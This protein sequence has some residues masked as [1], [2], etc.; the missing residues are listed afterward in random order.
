MIN[1]SEITYTL[2][3]KDILANGDLRKTRNGKVRSVFNKRL[4]IKASE[5]PLLSQ[6][7]IN[8]KQVAGELATFISGDVNKVTLNE[9]GCTYWDPIFKKFPKTKLLY[10]K[11]WRNFNGYDQLRQVIYTLE[12][13][14]TSRRILISNA[15][16]D[17][18]LSD[19]LP[20]CHI[21]YQWYVTK[22]GQLEMI[23][24]QRSVDV[25]IG[26]PHDMV[27]ASLFNRLLAMT[28]GLKCGNIYMN[29]GDTHIYETHVN[30]ANNFLTQYYFD[31]KLIVKIKT[32]DNDILNFKPADLT[33]KNYAPKP[34][35]YKFKL[36]I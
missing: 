25:M 18:N 36:T 5:F 24:T 3:V 22:K 15:Q 4:T 34:F 35:N 6:R 31:Q 1:P 17:S 7:Y 11:L 29:F 8:Y 30:I 33:V 9:N 14:P 2:L 16:A 12:T 27:L 28:V 26:L 13:E 20:C 19:N 32:K 10:G 21:I 23:W